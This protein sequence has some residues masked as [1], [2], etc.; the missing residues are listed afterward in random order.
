M[1]NILIKCKDRFKDWIV[2]LFKEPVKRNTNIMMFVAPLISVWVIE[3]LNKRSVI[4]GITCLFTDPLVFM[5]NYIIVFG[6]VSVVLLLKKRAAAIIALNTVW[7]GLGVANYVMKGYRETP[8]SA[9]DIKMAGS[10]ADIIEK[11]LSPTSFI[12]I[13]MLFIVAVFVVLFIWFKT[14]KY[15]KKLNYFANVLLMAFI[16]LFMFGCVKLGIKSNIV[17]EKFPNMSIAYQDYG[18]VYCFSCSVVNTGVEKPKTY[19]TASIEE[20]KDKLLN[21][22]TVDEENVKTPN[23]IFLQLESFFDVNKMETLE[24]SEDPI[25]IFNKL[26]EEFPSGFLTVNNLGYGTANTEFEIMT[27]M[28]LEDFGPGEFPYKTVLKNQTCE[29]IA[30]V[31]KDYG[32]ATHAMHN[33][34]ATFYSRH[35]VFKNLGYDTFTSIEFMNPEEYTE[36]GWA[37]DKVLTSEI[38]DVLEATDERDYLYCISVQG[39]G[40]YPKENVIE[41]PAIIVG[42]LDGDEERIYQFEFYVNQ[43]KEMDTFV[44]ELIAALEEVDEDTILVM[45]GDHF[46]SLGIDENE[47]SEGNLYQTEYVVW[48]NFDLELEDKD[49]ETHQL[50]SRVLQS[51][52]IDGGYI[53]KYHQIYQGEDDYLEQL[54]ILT[55]DMLYG[56]MYIFDG[57]NPYISTDLVY[58]VYPVTIKKVVRDLDAE[59]SE[60]NVDGNYYYLVKGSYFT[61]FSV[62]S[63]NGTQVTTEFIDEETLQIEVDEP[64]ESFDSVVVNQKWKASIVSK[65]SEYIYITVDTGEDDP[66]IPEVPDEFDQEENIESNEGTESETKDSEVENLEE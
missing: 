48:N 30:Y 35:K 45:Y 27:G 34:N 50:Y 13:L 53:N 65:T 1:K 14:P 19:S 41:N 57:T 2:S 20:I 59:Q 8:F 52:N 51:I 39:H 15:A 17:S 21:T 38:V 25:P 16:M 55:Y 36:V 64:L 40:T 49:I 28:N 11:Y 7:I 5:L 29:S 9:T 32:Y 66:V 3:I 18:F 62:V 12:V 26:K 60:A 58:G 37:K 6:T 56:D 33:N 24:L 4:K 63:I 31:L 23:I 61:S 46:P 44:G 43:I 10:V 54:K 22:V 47:L 42:G